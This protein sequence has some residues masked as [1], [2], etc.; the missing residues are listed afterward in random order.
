MYSIIPL[1][2]PD[3]FNPRYGI[4]PLFEID[5]QTI[6]KKIL[7]SRKW[8][9]EGEVQNKDLI[10]V[11]RDT[12]H[13]AQFEEYLR[14][15]FQGCQIVQLSDFTKGALLSCLA[16]TS[17][18]KNF[19]CPII[20]DLIDINFQIDREFSIA[21]TFLENKD[22]GAILPYFKS[23]NLEYSYVDIDNNGYVTSTKEKSGW[24]FK[25]NIKPK[26]GNASA[27]VYCFRNLSIFLNS[28]ADSLNNYQCY[29]HNE[30][31]FLCPAMNGV[32]KNGARV[33][34]IFVDTV[35]SVGLRFK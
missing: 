24:I 30:N 10:F 28:V 32:I 23:N 2:G 25:E 19:N 4:K 11:L 12:I 6:I 33:F 8:I 22:I 26:L 15:E 5:G 14:M 9:K 21:K 34:G 16:A 27:G 1:A 3:F 17:L 29:Q 7:G 35:E 31:L 20:C 18:I 13:T